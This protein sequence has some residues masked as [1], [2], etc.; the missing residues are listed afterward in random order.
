[1]NTVLKTQHSICITFQIDWC[2]YNPKHRAAGC[3]GYGLLPKGDEST[4]K[5]A[6]A[7]IGPISVAIDS[8]RSKF[9]FYRRGE[10][11][12]DTFYFISHM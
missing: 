11:W 9:M 1:M 6:V 12:L 8:S 10:W 5:E 7:T 3:S 2:K 4:L